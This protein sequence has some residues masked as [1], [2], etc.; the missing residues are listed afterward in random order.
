MGRYLAPRRVEYAGELVVGNVAP[1][2]FR[3][4]K[5]RQVF[6]RPWIAR[7]ANLGGKPRPYL[8][9]CRE[10]HVVCSRDEIAANLARVFG[11]DLRRDVPQLRRLW[12]L[13]RYPCRES[14]PARFNERKRLGGDFLALRRSHIRRPRLV[15]PQ[16]GKAVGQLMFLR[17]YL[18]KPRA[19]YGFLHFAD[20]VGFLV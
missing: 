9:V 12:V 3:R 7:A 13:L 11:G 19:E 5:P 10:Y 6:P 14:A 15:K 18:G 20:G 16:G 17:L 8:L 4:V 1:F 2:A